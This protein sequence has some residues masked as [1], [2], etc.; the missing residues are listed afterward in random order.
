M[1]KAGHGD[2]AGERSAIVVGGGIGPLAAALALVRSG[3]QVKVL[4]R[5]VTFG[6]V[7]AGLS[8]WPSAVQSVSAGRPPRPGRNRY[9]RCHQHAST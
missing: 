3:W 9:L 4:A 1:G 6:E 5:A 2:H 7:G 8:L